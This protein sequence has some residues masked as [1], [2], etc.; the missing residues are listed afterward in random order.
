MPEHHRR[1]HAG[2][3][4]KKLSLA[5]WWQDRDRVGWFP[6]LNPRQPGI[7]SPHRPGGSAGRRE[8]GAIEIPPTIS[9]AKKSSKLL[10]ESEDFVFFLVAPSNDASHSRSR[11]AETRGA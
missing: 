7:P 11:G 2:A 3:R 9:N 6:P 10:M 5:D 4:D 1:D 8:E